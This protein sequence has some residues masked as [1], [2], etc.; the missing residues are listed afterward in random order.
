MKPSELTY[1][2]N[3]LVNLDYDNK[4]IEPSFCTLAR[5]LLQRRERPSRRARAPGEK[6]SRDD[7]PER[8]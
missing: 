5:D 3:N 7:D 8:V 4:V 2:V 6:E 1:V